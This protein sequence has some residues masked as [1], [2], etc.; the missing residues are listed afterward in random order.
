MRL[1]LFELR[2]GLSLAPLQ[3]FISLLLGC[4]LCV[5]LAGPGVRLVAGAAPVITV[6][7]EPLVQVAGRSVTF[8]VSAES[9]PEDGAIAYQWFFNG[10]P[11]S[12]TASKKATYTFTASLARAGDYFVRATNKAGGSDSEH[13]ALTV[14][15]RPTITAQPIGFTLSRRQTLTLS[16]AA[17]GTPAPSFQWFLDDEPIPGATSATYQVESASAFDTGVYKVAVTNSV[18]TVFSRPASVVVRSEP[19][20]LDSPA[21]T[22]AYIGVPL[23]L[24]VTAIGFP[25]RS[26]QW[27]LD[28]QAI[29]G[30]R[31]A[32][33]VLKP[34]FGKAGRYDVVVSNDFGVAVCPAFTV[35]VKGA[36]KPLSVPRSAK[37]RVGQIFD[38]Q[39]DVQADPWPTFQWLKDG[40]EMPG[41]T[42]NA[43]FLPPVK[44]TDEGVYSA[45][46][47]NAFGGFD[48]KPV[49]LRVSIAP[50]GP[51]KGSTYRFDT[52]ISSNTGYGDDINLNAKFTLGAGSLSIEDYTDGT[53]STEPLEF[54][55]VSNERVRMRFYDRVDGVKLTLTMNFYFDTPKT[56][57]VSVSVY[58]AGYGTIGSGSSSFIY[59]EPGL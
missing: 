1:G 24:S 35:A 20:I 47:T 3:R 22:E 32:V 58:A 30:A 41:Q 52:W 29:P 34:S 9:S 53:R 10:D 55:R 50:F 2:L 19:I 46:V 17:T 33:Y 57:S 11:I 16:V 39:V 13:I 15:A 12:G 37:L 25:K 54:T 23:R 38:C 44:L 18:A 48:T 42:F 21:D 4:A 14:Q 59:T 27:R 49:K 8:R 36:P 31:S 28:G 45:H 43:L 40:V 56:G 51:V 5:G 26:Y 6:Q 7:P